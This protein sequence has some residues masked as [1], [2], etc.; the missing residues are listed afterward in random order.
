VN[1]QGQTDLTIGRLKFSG[2]AQRR[3]KG[4]LIFHGTFLL[5]FD[6]ALI[7][8]TLPFPSRQ[9]TY[10]EYRSHCD[11][12]T[13]LGVSSEIIKDALIKAWS[14]FESLEEIPRGRIS[15]LALEKY[16]QDEWNLKFQE[17]PQAGGVNNSIL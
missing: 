12:L 5:H 8:K 9:P 3:R 1:L 17:K 16:E 14:A 4:F 2:N 10:R 11:F 6:L 7:E 13:N 15:Q